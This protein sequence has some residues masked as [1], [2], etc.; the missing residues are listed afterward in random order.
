[1][2]ISKPL[3]SI[4]MAVYEPNL[5]WLGEQLASLESQTYPNLELIVCDD[6][7]LTVQF[8]EIRSCVET[9]ISSL[10]FELYR[11]FENLG[12]NKTFERLTLWA[13]GRYIAYCDQDDVW[14]SEKLSVLIQ[15]S[16]RTGALLVC[17]D[18]YIVNG[19]GEMVADSITKVRRHHVLRSGVGLAKGLLFSNFVTGCTMIVDAETAKAAVPFCP[20]MIHDHYLA[21]YVAS[22]GAICSVKKPLIRY[23]LHSANQTGMMA[24]VYDKESYRTERIDFAVK[25][26]CWLNMN[27][28]APPPLREVIA[29][30]LEWTKARQRYFAGNKACAK[31]VWRYRKFEPLTAAF[32]IASAVIP[33]SLF[34]FFINLKKKNLV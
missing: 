4:V 17:S 33:E 3:I 15:A 21:L 5:D 28:D 2:E 18:M 10:P 24:G 6:C 11:N 32:E 27:F 26:M 19:D 1:M 34:M 12:S 31:T 7:S 13:K 8:E 30:G 16:E 25:R 29:Q 14:L 20:F 22:R 23:R 9:H